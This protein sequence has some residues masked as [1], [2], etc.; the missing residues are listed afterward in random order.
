[1]G[2]LDT[3]PLPNF[4]YNTI[5]NK[6]CTITM[7]LLDKQKNDEFLTGISGT[8]HSMK[9]NSYFVNSLCVWA[10]NHVITTGKS[11]A[12]FD[13]PAGNGIHGTPV[14][15]L[16]VF[17]KDHK[18]YVATLDMLTG[19]VLKRS[20]C[21]NNAQPKCT[22]AIIDLDY[23]PTISERHTIKSYCEKD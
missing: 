22:W 7:K 16:G 17:M 13:Y 23:F 9:N 3:L 4:R 12:L 15:L 14:K 6:D 20:Q 21:M 19:E 10:D 18:I 1:M 5:Y 11:Y 2:G 8:F